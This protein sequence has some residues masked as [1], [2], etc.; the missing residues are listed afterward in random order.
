MSS[1]GLAWPVLVKV[2]NSYYWWFFPLRVF[3][4]NIVVIAM[5]FIL[6]LFYFISLKSFG[7]HNIL[8]L[9]SVEQ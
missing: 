9:M 6:V 5:W 4:V 8:M 7:A 1:L 3:H 2:N